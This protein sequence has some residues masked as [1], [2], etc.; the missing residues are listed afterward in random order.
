LVIG[1]PAFTYLD[2]KLPA[3]DDYFGAKRSGQMPDIL[4]TPE[5]WQVMSFSSSD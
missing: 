5:D 3:L 2:A 4:V 1:I